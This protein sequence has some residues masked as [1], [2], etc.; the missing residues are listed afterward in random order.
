MSSDPEAIA[1]ATAAAATPEAA[2]AAAPAVDGAAPAD[3][4]QRAPK[5]PKA[6]KQPKVPQ[7]PGKK[8]GAAA[9][10]AEVNKSGI[11]A[12]KATDFAKWYSQVVVR[13]ELIE[14]YPDISGCYILRPW[15]YAIWETIQVRAAPPA[16]ATAILRVLHV[17][18]INVIS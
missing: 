5:E 3:K 12:S 8:A 10:A 16:W 9:A 6:P 13:S 2:P 7:G 18:S 11:T 1:A 4:P 15:S 14:Y 17:Y